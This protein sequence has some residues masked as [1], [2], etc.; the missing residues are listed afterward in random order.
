MLQRFAVADVPKVF[1]QSEVWPSET[2]E[3]WVLRD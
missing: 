3:F 1:Y 2:W